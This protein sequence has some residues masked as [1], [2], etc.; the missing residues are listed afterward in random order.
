MVINVS[1][2]TLGKGDMT[3]SLY[4]SPYSVLSCL[5]TLSPEKMLEGGRWRVGLIKF[6]FQIILYT[7]V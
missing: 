7:A 2:Y 3:F 6:P 5:K 4:P 1:S